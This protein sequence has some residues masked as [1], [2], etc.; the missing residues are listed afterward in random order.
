MWN[1]FTIP[2]LCI[3]CL[4]STWMFD[5]YMVNLCYGTNYVLWRI[6]MRVKHTHVIGHTTMNPYILVI[7]ELE[8][9]AYVMSSTAD[10][11][12]LI[13]EKEF[14]HWM[15]KAEKAENHVY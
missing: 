3:R 8:D 9:G 13:G 5:V 10:N 15:E 14:N 11:N 12:R 4:V 2:A 7:Y 6:L 1:I